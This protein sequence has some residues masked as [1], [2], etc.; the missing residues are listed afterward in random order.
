MI[1]VLIISLIRICFSLASGGLIY[2]VKGAGEVLHARPR[3]YEAK[4][5]VLS[6]TLCARFLR[7]PEAPVPA[8]RF[9]FL[10]IRLVGCSHWFALLCRALLCFALHRFALFCIALYYL[11]IAMIYNALYR[12]NTDSRALLYLAFF[13][14]RRLLQTW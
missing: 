11:C 10:L 8:P 4:P 12:L 6:V 13:A 2:F 7:E 3:A 1:C 5:R 14:L 9:R